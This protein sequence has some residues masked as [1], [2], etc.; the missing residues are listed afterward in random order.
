MHVNALRPVAGEN[1]SQH[2]LLR[3]AHALGHTDDE[4]L[5][6]ACEA[7]GCSNSVTVKDAY[8]MAI[9]YRMPGRDVPGFQCAEEQHL[10]CS[11][12][13]AKAAMLACLSEHI[14]PVHIQLG[15]VQA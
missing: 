4:Q 6:I 11:H 10:G 13:H 5:Y 8:S 3:A 14:E 7:P 12:A 9:V 2:R 15:G 1:A